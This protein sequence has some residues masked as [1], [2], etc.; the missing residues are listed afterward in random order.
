MS[1]TII[2]RP[3]IGALSLRLRVAD[4]PPE[5]QVEIFSKA[6][7]E[8]LG[9]MKDADEQLQSAARRAGSLGPK[10][11][12]PLLHEAIAKAHDNLQPMM[13]GFAA[14]LDQPPD[15]TPVLRRQLEQCQQ[16]LGDAQQQLFKLKQERDQLEKLLREREARIAD[17]EAQN[18]ALAAQLDEFKGRVSTE[19]TSF[20]AALGQAV[21]AI[22][23][24]LTSLPNRYVDYGLQEFDLQTQ[25]NLQI[26]DGGRLLIRFPG[27]NEQIAPQN[28]SQ[29]HMRLRPIP[30]EQQEPVE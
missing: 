23:A 12:A 22:Q 11:G 13:D 4:Q 6:I 20:G 10:E 29:L 24:G 18:A 17:L 28:L 19:P 27:L 15:E 30:K 9:R 21:D 26:A 5:K 3:R 25:V 2:T 7:D 8:A 1:D 16:D 14:A